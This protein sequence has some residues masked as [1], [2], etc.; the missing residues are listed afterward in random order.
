MKNKRSQDD[1]L[2]EMTRIEIERIRCTK[3]RITM[4]GGS[5]RA[6]QL[7]KAIFQCNELLKAL[8][9]ELE[10]IRFEGW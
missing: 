7:D 4:M 1:V 8:D 10:D 3:E 9:Q 5:D 6:R 2:D